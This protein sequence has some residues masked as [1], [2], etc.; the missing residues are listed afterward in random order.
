MRWSTARWT[1]Q[2]DAQRSPTTLP[3][4]QVTGEASAR[5]ERSG[6]MVSPPSREHPRA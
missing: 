6:V 4:G 1:G 3:A 2:S 5:S